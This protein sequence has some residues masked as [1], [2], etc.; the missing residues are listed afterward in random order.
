MSQAPLNHESPQS[1]TNPEADPSTPENSK[2][3]RSQAQT[4]YDSSSA[5]PRK[6]RWA[7]AILP[8]LIGGGVIVA[9]TS[10]KHADVETT[11]SASVGEAGDS[12]DSKDAQAAD[13]GKTPDAGK[14]SDEALAGF[15]KTAQKGKSAKAKKSAVVST[16]TAKSAHRAPAENVYVVQIGAFRVKQNAE[17]L[18]EKLKGAGFA[19]E[20]QQIQHSSNGQL[21]LVRLNP[22]ADRQAAEE[23]RKNLKA[24]IDIDSMILA[25]PK[26]DRAVSSVGETNSGA[27]KPA[28]ASKGGG[29]EASQSDSRHSEIR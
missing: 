28:H 11:T 10:H 8:I 3:Q 4:T 9:C 25:L 14:S 13:A 24:K 18:N 6:L 27:P 16:K 19:V 15:T 23:M 29:Q 5:S 1:S 7:L 12:A 26:S 21:F 2:N 22:T 17:K 20:L